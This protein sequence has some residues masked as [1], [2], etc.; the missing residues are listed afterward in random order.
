MTAKTATTGHDRLEALPTLSDRLERL[1]ALRAHLTKLAANRAEI[2][3][4]P[5]P[6][7][8]ARSR[9]RGAIE[10]AAG[11]FAID[12]AAWTR[13]GPPPALNLGELLRAS[14]TEMLAALAGTAL[15]AHA[16]AGLKALYA[17]DDRKP[18]NDAAR[19]RELASIDALIVATG[20][21]EEF[22]V[23]AIEVAGGGVQRRA[24]ASPEIILS[25]Q[26]PA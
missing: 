24:D 25:A 1:A 11:R 17:A 20:R 22:T 14:P 18:L 26:E 12:L 21:M 16:E 19:A 5:I 8:E 13:P 10:A 23:L 4:A 15:L 6:E 9:L 3:R 7:A 2:E